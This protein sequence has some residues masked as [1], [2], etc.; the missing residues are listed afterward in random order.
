MRGCAM[1]SPPSR[2]HFERES[3][4]GGA[5]ELVEG[6][7]SGN[8]GFCGGA[9]AP[10]VVRA[11]LIVGDKGN[12]SVD[13]EQL[14]GAPAP[15]TKIADRFATL[16]D[17]ET[18]LVSLANDGSVIGAAWPVFRNTVS[19]EHGIP[20]MTEAEAVSLLMSRKCTTDLRA[21]HHSGVR[22]PLEPTLAQRGCNRCNTSPGTAL[23]AGGTAIVLAAAVVTA[24]ILRR[25]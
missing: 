16:T 20:D 9:P 17:G 22:P 19:L 13:V 5:A 15:T 2:N 11:H 3:I 25:R 7:M 6:R 24:A 23:D 8:A 18:L 4:Q 21:L 12:V 10:T 14:Y 1:S